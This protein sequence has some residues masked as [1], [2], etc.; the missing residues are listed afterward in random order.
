ML[1]AD[2]TYW[3][4]TLNNGA[5]DWLAYDNHDGIDYYFYDDY[6]PIFAAAD[7]ERAVRAGWENPKNHQQGFGLRVRLH[8]ANGYETLYGHLS[9]IAV[10][11]CSTNCVPIAQGNI[12]GI[13]GSTGQ[14][15]AN[16]LHFG[17]YDSSSN[18]I[19]RRWRH[20]R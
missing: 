7:A 5:G 1:G 4:F 2:T 16:H 9:A 3:S 14:S 19:P 13:S 11:A 6:R 18:T 12:I 15:T 8:H 10:Q 17:V 20:G